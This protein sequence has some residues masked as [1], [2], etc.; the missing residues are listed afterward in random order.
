MSISVGES[1]HAEV[2]ETPMEILEECKTS[3]YNWSS[4]GFRWTTTDP[5]QSDH[6]GNF[7]L[8]YLLK[9]F[10]LA[11][12]CHW[13]DL[14][15]WLSS[16]DFPSW[17]CAHTNNGD[18]L[19]FGAGQL[20]LSLVNSSSFDSL[21]PSFSMTTWAICMRSTTY[22]PPSPFP[23]K[24]LCCK[25][26]YNVPQTGLSLQVGVSQLGGFYPESLHQSIKRTHSCNTCIHRRTLSTILLP[27]NNKRPCLYLR[28]RL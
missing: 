11:Q 12:F 19:E 7:P 23:Q 13:C 15:G 16:F 2:E 20:Y 18:R 1:R 17:V 25:G 27:A 22:I 3:I 24:V 5:E 4:P 9:C 6:A 8:I 14:I 21:S 26:P 10:A 28:V